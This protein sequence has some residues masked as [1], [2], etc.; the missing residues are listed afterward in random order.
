MGFLL[1]AACGGAVSG[2]DGGG[3]DSSAPDASGS[4][5]GGACTPGDTRKVDCNTCTCAADGRWACTGLA[6]VDAMPPL[7]VSDPGFVTC[8]GAPCAVPAD[9]CCDASLV[10]MSSTQKCVPQTM[11]ACGVLRRTCDEAADC[12]GGQVCCIPPNANIQIA[13]NAQCEA[14]GSCKDP[15]Y[16]PQL[17][18]TSAECDNGMACVMQTCLGA[19]VWTCGGIDP[20]RCQ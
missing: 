9:M 11:S 19:V 16:F 12:G 18:K 4:E 15:T 20:K 5:G 13:L 1:S 3:G 14:K 10:P 6:C 8:A 2:G 17:C 7:P